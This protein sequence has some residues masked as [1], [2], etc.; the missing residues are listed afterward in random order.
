[1]E[2]PEDFYRELESSQLRIGDLGY[3]LLKLIEAYHRAGAPFGESG[4]GLRVWAGY[5]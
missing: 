2:G 1:M 3:N 5:R 4:E